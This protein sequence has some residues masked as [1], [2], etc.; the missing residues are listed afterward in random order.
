MAS[1][2]RRVPP[3]PTGPFH[4]T[5]VTALKQLVPSR[6]AWPVAHARTLIELLAMTTVPVDAIPYLIEELTVLRQKESRI[7][8]FLNPVLRRL[9][10]E[11]RESIR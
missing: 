9:R 8:P 2:S 3:P 1:R 10:R 4:R 5:I 6:G 7:R 11:R